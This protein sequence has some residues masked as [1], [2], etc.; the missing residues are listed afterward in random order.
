MAA[1]RQH[2]VQEWA[3]ELSKSDP[4]V[5]FCVYGFH[6]GC[7]TAIA[8]REAGVDA[9]FMKGGHSAWRAIGGAMRL[10]T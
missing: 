7:K 10:D 4:V 3:G 6:I 5:V 2:R 9:K 8:L 1:R